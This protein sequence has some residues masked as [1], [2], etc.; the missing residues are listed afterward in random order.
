MQTSFL[1]VIFSIMPLP[2][3]ESMPLTPTALQAVG[4]SGILT[5]SGEFIIQD[6]KSIAHWDKRGNLIRQ[7]TPELRISSI[8]HYQGFLWVSGTED[9]ENR[10]LI[11]KDGVVAA[12]QKGLFVPYFNVVN[13]ELFIPYKISQPFFGNG[14]YFYRH[15]YLMQ[16]TQVTWRT[17][18]N[19]I[20]LKPTGFEFYRAT[21][22][23]LALHFNFKRLW[24][25]KRD[26]VFFVANE[27]EPKL[28]IYTPQFIEHD[29]RLGEAE[30]QMSASKH[31]SLIGF[32]PPTKLWEPE[33]SQPKADVALAHQQW[34]QCLNRITFFG[35]Y[36]TRKAVI[37]Y[38]GSPTNCDTPSQYAQLLDEHFE[39][40]GRPSEI[41]G[42]VLGSYQGKLFC[43]GMEAGKPFVYSYTLSD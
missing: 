29:L 36:G 14:D 26:G 38:F 41:K 10:T 16:V 32:N 28:R 4:T 21:P 18:R 3:H 23:M 27:I 40:E 22:A 13:G 9:H 35:A 12:Q 39:L 19:E 31:I 11:Y 42:Q 20:S 17:S 43:F 2:K 24:I 6:G 33:K 25:M 30:T 5:S 37:T 34:W 15:N 8:L 1:L 7:L